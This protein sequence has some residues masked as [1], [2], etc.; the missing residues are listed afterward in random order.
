MWFKDYSINISVSGRL[1]NR[2]ETTPHQR[3]KN[4]SLGNGRYVAH[5]KLCKQQ[6]VLKVCG[7]VPEENY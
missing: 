4:P 3:K 2:P 6:V 1:N 7:T 5:A